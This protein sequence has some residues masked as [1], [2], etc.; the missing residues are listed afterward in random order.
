M[1]TNHPKLLEQSVI[2]PAGQP[3]LVVDREAGVIRGVKVLGRFSPNCHGLKG[4]TEGTEYTPACFKASASLYEGAKIYTN[5]PDEKDRKRPASPRT[6]DEPLGVLRNCVAS[7]DGLR[8]DL[9]YLK[10]HPMANR[11]C[12]DVER[13]MGVFGLSHNADAGA[14][15]VVNGKL[16]IESI[17]KVHS[18]DLVDKPATNK[19][20]WESH[21]MP[22]VTLRH[23]VEAIKFKGTRARW[24]LKVLEDGETADAP[25]EAPAEE[26][27]P[28][29]AMSDG[30]RKAC[31][32]VVDKMIDGETDLAEGLKKLKDLITSHGKLTAK[33]DPEEPVA[34][35]D[36][37]EE[38]DKK[39][40]EESVESIV[41]AQIQEAL[42]NFDL[43]PK[44]TVKTKSGAPAPKAGDKNVQEGKEA[45]KDGKAFASLILSE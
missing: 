8:A 38:E 43:K 40:T 21:A 33:A 18:V 30:F 15:R 19:N 24:A 14:S 28:E 42:K 20:L 25:M 37:S 23:L 2:G 4:V 16:V 6:I 9:H 22:T 34:E 31:Y 3:P 5:H 36:D 39:K 17:A 29:D 45:P 35:E 26:T 11:V 13:G 1:A 10:S 27:T 32:S 44:P 12:E 7:D 41:K